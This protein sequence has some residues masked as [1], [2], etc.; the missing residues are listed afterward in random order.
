MEVSHV[1]L[2]LLCN[3]TTHPSD[4]AR[5]RMQVFLRFSRGFPASKRSSGDSPANAERVAPPPEA[6]PRAALASAASSGVR[7]DD[8]MASAKASTSKS[9]ASATNGDRT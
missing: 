9:Y 4:T 8:Q 6:S 3:S 2:L 7:S 1:Q 5:L